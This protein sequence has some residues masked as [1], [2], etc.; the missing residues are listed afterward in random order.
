MKDPKIINQPGGPDDVWTFEVPTYKV[1][2][3]GMQDGE[4]L[5]IKLCRGNIADESAPRQ[6]GVFSETLITVVKTYLEKVNAPGPLST[7]ET[8]MVITKLDEALMWIQKR[9]DDRK[10]REVQG[11]YKP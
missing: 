9:A 2:N 5:I 4:P 7:R 3:E 11:T 1:T 6:E 10:R 8:S